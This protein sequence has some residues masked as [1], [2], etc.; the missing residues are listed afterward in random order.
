MARSAFAALE[1]CGFA[2]ISGAADSAIASTSSMV[3]T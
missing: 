1:L 2:G 3:L